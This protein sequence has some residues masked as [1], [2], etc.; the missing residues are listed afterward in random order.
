MKPEERIFDAMDDL[1]DAVLEDTARA[2]RR[3]KR[4]GRVWAGLAVAACLALA[5]GGLW[6]LRQAD[7]DS[8]AC[9]AAAQQEGDHNAADSAQSVQASGSVWIPAIE[10]PE[11][12]EGV[13]MDMIGTLVYEGRI[14]QQAGRRYEAGSAAASLV[15]TYLGEASGRLTEW[16]EQSDYAE[17][18]AST[19]KGPV[20]TVEGYDPSFRLCMVWPDSGTV[21]FY[22]CLNGITI[23]TGADVFAERLT[24]EQGY[25][26]AVYQLHGDWNEATGAFYELEDSAVLDAFLQALYEASAVNPEPYDGSV[27]ELDQRFITLFLTDGT[28]VTLRLFA[29][30]TV[31]YE[32]PSIRF[33]MPGAAFDALWAACSGA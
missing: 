18:L 8:E 28:E 7:T 32:S 30:G 10:L 21:E 31:Q 15:G 16:S 26:G 11:L 2:L 1:D 19:G 12:E 9:Y 4:P 13:A 23:A 5:A 22:E 33:T 29:N 25:T 3:P 17:K 20:Y 14:Y 24:L 27:Y 6:Y